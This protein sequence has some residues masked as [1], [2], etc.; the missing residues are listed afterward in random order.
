MPAAIDIRVDLPAP[1]AP[2]RAM[3]LLGGRVTVKSFRAQS[4]L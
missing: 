3:T 1:F 4:F 2:T